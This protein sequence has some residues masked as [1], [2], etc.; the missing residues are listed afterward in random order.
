MYIYSAHICSLAS[1][2]T[3]EWIWCF[4]FVYFRH[5]FWF[6]PKLELGLL[7]STAAMRHGTA[8]K[9][10]PET[11]SVLTSK[12]LEK[13]TNSVIGLVP[14]LDSVIWWPLPSLSSFT[15]PLHFFFVAHS[16]RT[17]ECSTYTNN[18]IPNVFIEN[19]RS[20]AHSLTRPIFRL[21][22]PPLNLC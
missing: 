17:F 20:L 4:Q 13:Q 19:P 11:C 5:R 2:T 16:C 3:S 12:V 14:I 6:H 9:S 18:S 1:Q 10:R 7:S 15:P 21:P 8:L 22:Q